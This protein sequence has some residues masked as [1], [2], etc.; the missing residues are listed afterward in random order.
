MPSWDELS[1]GAKD[2]LSRAYD[3]ISR[4]RYKKERGEAIGRGMNSKELPESPGTTLEV[5][6]Y[7]DKAKKHEDH[8]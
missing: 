2:T 4:D 7:L 8:D 3:L 1:E 6:Y 5:P